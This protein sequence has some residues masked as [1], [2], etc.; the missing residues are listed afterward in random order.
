[1]AKEGWEAI[2]QQTGASSDYTFAG[3]P[4]GYDELVLRGSVQ[5][6][7][8]T[9]TQ[10]VDLRCNGDTGTNY[11]YAKF[12]TVA[13]NT[14]VQ[15]MVNNGSVGYLAHVGG[16]YLGDWGC[17]FECW[18]SNVSNSDI[19]TTWVSR[20]ALGGGANGYNAGG[21]MAGAWKNTAAI[22]SLT[23]VNGNWNAPSV[24]TLWGRKS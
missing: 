23:T 21:F 1:M 3:I 4:A 6:A 24:M 9:F 2:G 12:G 22:T 19:Y 15:T 7:T 16:S 20:I 5:S 10:R 14:V 17:W 11:T 13:N 18:L 8:G